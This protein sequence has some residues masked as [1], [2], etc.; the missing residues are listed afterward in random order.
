MACNGGSPHLVVLVVAVGLLLDSLLVTVIVVPNGAPPFAP[1]PGSFPRLLPP[2][3]SPGSFPRLLP[4]APSPGSFPRLLPP[5]ASNNNFHAEFFTAGPSYETKPWCFDTVTVRSHCHCPQPLSLSAATVTVRSHCPRS[6]PIAPMLL[7]SFEHPENPTNGTLASEP[8][9]PSHRAPLLGKVMPITP[10]SGSSLEPLFNYS[11]SPGQRHNYTSNSSRCLEESGFL[12]KNNFKVGA[13]LASKSVAQLLVS[14]FVGPLT[15][16]I[17]FHIPMFVGFLVFFV[18]TL[19]FAFAGNFV[20]LISARVVQGVGSSFSFVAG[21][22]MLAS[23]YTDD[24]ERGQAMGVALGGLALGLICGGPFG[25]VMYEFVGKSSP[26]LVLAG[27]ALL[28]GVLQLCVLK[29]TL[30][31]PV[32]AKGTPLLTLL[33][34]PYILLTAGALTLSGMALTVQDATL[35]TWMIETMCA[36]QLQL[37]MMFTPAN[38]IYFITTNLFG[39][40]SQRMGRWL[41]SMIGMILTGLS[42]LFAALAKSFYA[43]IGAVAVTGM[44]MGMVEVSLLPVLA[45]LVDIRHVSVYGNVFTVCEVAV[46]LGFFVGPLVGGALVQ[47]VGYPVLMVISGLVNILYAP[48][49]YFL[50]NPPTREEK[51]PIVDRYSGHGS[52]HTVEPQPQGAALIYSPVTA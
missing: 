6:L 16:R 29:P 7:Y 31:P 18:S 43:V 35:P 28:S 49:C 33:R 19:M 10:S 39:I 12:H 5:A 3:P 24:E 20:L 1:S 30:V 22:G 41:C 23:V 14:F 51:R 36:S 21:L 26:F 8:A 50:R 48:L 11:R 17:G 9:M 27:L 42:F 2:A 47:A 38:V 44:S 52:C 32:S 40:L 46:R 34:D 45:H 15:N 25:S 4:P 13:L 37:G